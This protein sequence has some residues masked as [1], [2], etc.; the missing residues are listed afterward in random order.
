[1]KK[2]AFFM[3][4]P[5]ILSIV[6]CG[7][8]TVRQDADWP[9]RKSEIKTIAVAVNKI[10]VVEVN[11]TGDGGHVKEQE[12]ALAQYSE[13]GLV[14]ALSQ[15]GFVGRSITGEELSSN[16]DL[17]FAVKEL[18]QSYEAL[19]K[20]T[21]KTPAIHEK[22]AYKTDLNVGAAAAPVAAAT[23]SDAILLVDYDGFTISSG[24]MVANIVVGA[25]LGSTAVPQPA[26]TSRFVLI[27]GH[28]G[29]VLCSNMVSMPGEPSYAAPA[30]S[31]AV[32]K[33]MLS[34]SK[35]K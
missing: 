13:Q 34:V 29:D 9:A 23:G 16:P 35:A 1:M 21:Y 5:V 3:V 14:N 6:G 11:M 26:V 15:H 2:I 18:A 17:A 32:L 25:L 4:M 27:D 7:Y 8:T 30:Q 20:E 24:K 31:G 19:A 12:K 22:I 33:D 28:N 10:N